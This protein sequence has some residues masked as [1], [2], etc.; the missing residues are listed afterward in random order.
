MHTPV[1]AAEDE[2]YELAAY[3][4]AAAAQVQAAKDHMNAVAERLMALDSADTAA[5]E[6]VKKELAEVSI[7]AECANLCITA[8]QRCTKHTVT[9]TA[10]LPLCYGLQAAQT[11]SSVQVHLECMLLYLTDSMIHSGQGI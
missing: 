5:L 2:A 7:T 3:K 8:Q 1:G 9:C 6:E 11:V 4:A 10:I